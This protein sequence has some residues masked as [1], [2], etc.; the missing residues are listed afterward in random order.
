MECKKITAP[1]SLEVCWKVKG[2]TRHL[3]PV[4]ICLATENRLLQFLPPPT[5]HFMRNRRS[6]E[7]GFL[8]HTFRGPNTMGNLNNQHQWLHSSVHR[9]NKWSLKVNTEIDWWA[10]P[11]SGP[12][13]VRFAVWGGEERQ[14]SDDCPKQ[15][16]IKIV[17]NAT[18]EKGCGQQLLDIYSYQPFIRKISFK[19]QQ[20]HFH[21][22]R[23][24]RLSIN[25]I[26]SSR[27]PTLAARGFWRGTEMT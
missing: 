14:Q 25:K 8:E 12:A 13:L 23:S 26:Q 16:E 20:Q 6:F 19:S 18:R 9:L 7:F 22:I 21:L 24:S 15:C 11:A 10:K 4:E 17:I 1:P 5:V 27:Q 2:R 3:S